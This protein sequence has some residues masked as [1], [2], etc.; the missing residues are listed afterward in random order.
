MQARQV[1][2]SLAL[3][4]SRSCLENGRSGELQLASCLRNSAHNRMTVVFT[5][6]F[7]EAHKAQNTT[8]TVLPRNAKT[9]PATDMCCTS[10][11][12]SSSFIRCTLLNFVHSTFASEL[13]PRAPCMMVWSISAAKIPTLFTSGLVLMSIDEETRSPRH[14]STRFTLIAVTYHSSVQNRKNRSIIAIETILFLA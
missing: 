10:T 4:R 1:C 3:L 12:G 5:E 7:S 11:L 9:Q 8:E 2:S 14:A 13:Y 6:G